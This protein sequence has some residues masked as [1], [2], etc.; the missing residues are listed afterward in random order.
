MRTTDNN[1]G[2]PLKDIAD[3]KS[4][5][6]QDLQSIANQKIGDLANKQNLL[7]FPQSFEKSPDGIESESVFSLH[8]EELITHNIMG[9]IGANDTQLTITSRF[10]KDDAHDYFLHYMLCKVMH[11][12]IFKFDISPD[13]ESIWDFLFYLFPHYLNK[14]LMQGLYKEYISNHYNNPNVKGA[15]NI[16][17]HISLNLPF[18]GNIA[19]S[20]RE[21]SCDN[22]ITQLIRHTIEHIKTKLLGNM[23]L[24]ANTEIREAVRQITAITPIYN[25]NDRAK[26]IAANNKP[27]SHP[28]FTEYRPLQKICLQ[29]LRHEKLTFGNEKDKVYGLL[30]DGA[31]LWEEYLNTI[32]TNDFKHPRNKTKEGKEYLFCDDNGK[33]EQ[34]IY[35]DF[36]SKIKPVIVADA[37]YKHLEYKNREDYLQIITYMYRFRSS[38]GFLLFPNSGNSVH[39]N[40]EIKCTEG[41]LTKLGL[42]IPQQSDNFKDFCE[43]IEENEEIFV[44]CI[45]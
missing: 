28:Y 13:K 45:S 3:G 8:D 9:F 21:H 24:S 23:I 37:K 41:K 26:I 16:N 30:F 14:A 22:H 33:G 34:E 7:I 40:Y 2:K 5:D 31:W 17:R 32:L 12:N 6:L 18:R 38:H 4:Y 11:L 29:I 35:P 42:A 1:C 39:K 19:Y 43:Q 36:I 25:K 20:M 44:S 15:V 27:V 10:A